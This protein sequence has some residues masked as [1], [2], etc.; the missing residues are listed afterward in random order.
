MKVLSNLLLLLTVSPFIAAEM[1][2]YSESKYIFSD[3]FEDSDFLEA[4]PYFS[5]SRSNVVKISSV[6]KTLGETSFKG[7]SYLRDGFG[8][9]P[10]EIAL[11]LKPIPIPSYGTMKEKGQSNEFAM[12]IK[13][14]KDGNWS[15]LRFDLGKPYKDL[16]VRYWLRVPTNFEHK[17]PG[18]AASNNKLFAIYMDDYSQKGTG[19]TM[20]WEYWRANDNIS[21][22][23]WHYRDVPTDI[24]TGHAQRFEFIDKSR[25][26]GRWM[27][28]ALHVKTSSSN[29]TPDGVVELYR[30][31]SDEAEFTL[32]HQSTTSTF[33]LPEDSAFAGW[34]KGYFMGWANSGWDE[35][36]H[37]LIDGVEFSETELLNINGVW[38]SN[39]P[40]SE[41]INPSYSTTK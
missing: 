12:D 8:G 24:N 39:S 26:R 6:S 34:R 7:I 31:W 9:E 19:A 17:D 38:K 4:D 18:S 29:G 23:A 22:L 41:K 5:W 37:W 25:D 2:I 1:T 11:N 15:E 13:Y 35:E 36:T 30:R 20:V 28:I 32:H 14:N 40:S 27:Q 10:E 33:S 21:E 16:W 3:S